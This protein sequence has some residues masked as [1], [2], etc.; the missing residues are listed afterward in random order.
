[1]NYKLKKYCNFIALDF[2]GNDKDSHLFSEIGFIVTPDIIQL[3][4]VIYQKGEKE[5]QNINQSI[6]DKYNVP[7]DLKTQYNA[8]TPNDVLNFDF[9]FFHPQITNKKYIFKYHPINENLYSSLIENSIWFGQANRLNDPFDTR[10]VIETEY[11]EK[12]ISKFYFDLNYNFRS[13]DKSIYSLL[14][15]EFYTSFKI[16]P[17]DEFLKDLEEHHYNNTFS[18]KIG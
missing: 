14:F 15:D 8:F 5:I 13:I 17:F 4:I 16:P 12:D 7:I 1:M 18:K 2:F 11:N 9:Y 3:K 6:K 10:Y